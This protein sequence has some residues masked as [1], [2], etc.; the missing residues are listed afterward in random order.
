M[1]EK[2]TSNRYSGTGNRIINPDH[3]A[4]VGIFE[5]PN[6][7]VN[8]SNA[9]QGQ[10]GEGHKIYEKTV[11]AL[12]G[13]SNVGKFGFH[14]LVV[15]F[16]NGG[17]GQGRREFEDICHNISGNKIAADKRST[18]VGF[19]NFG[20]VNYNCKTTSTKDHGKAAGGKAAGASSRSEANILKNEI[21][22]RNGSSNVGMFNF[23]NVYINA[24]RGQAGF[25]KHKGISHNIMGNTII[26]VNSRVVGIQGFGNIKYNCGSIISGL[27]QFLGLSY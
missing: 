26:A 25:L 14:N 15:D 8:W 11:T 20:N 21:T 10:G 6:S 22:A 24:A 17:R 2:D 23:H 3:A 18:K 16:S 9:A 1:E 12:N 27:L 5:H 19:E 7:G 4:D 13:E